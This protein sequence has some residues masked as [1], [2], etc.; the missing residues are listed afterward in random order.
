M[1]P[2]PKKAFPLRIEPALWAALERAAATDLAHVLAPILFH[3]RLTALARLSGEVRAARRGLTL[4]IR[5]LRDRLFFG[6][7]CPFVLLVQ[8]SPLLA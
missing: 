5:G 2:P 3:H 7:A 6:R 8:T 4:A 1:P